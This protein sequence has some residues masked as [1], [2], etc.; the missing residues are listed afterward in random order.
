VTSA[1]M[2]QCCLWAAA[3]CGLWWSPTIT[4]QP[5]TPYSP[6]RLCG[7]AELHHIPA[8]LQH[9]RSFT[10]CCG[11]YLETETGTYCFLKPACKV[12]DCD[13]AQV[14]DTGGLVWRLDED[15]MDATTKRQYAA[16]EDLP[17]LRRFTEAELRLRSIILGSPEVPH[18]HGL[19][20]SSR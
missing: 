14:C 16:I 6:V 10:I 15:L 5:C 12:P 1:S 17:N 2:L 13:L 11:I 4:L 18:M 20:G 7:H 8:W 9:C 19:M 3:T